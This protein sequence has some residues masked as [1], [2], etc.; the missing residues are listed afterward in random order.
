[1]KEIKLFP[2][3]GSFA[4]NKD[5]AKAIRISELTPA[6][7][8]NEKVALDFEGVTSATQSF[9]HALISEVIRREGVAVLDRLKFKNCD[10]TVKKMIAIVVSYMQ[11]TL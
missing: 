4:E 8:E 9:I 1:M 7:E 10:E 6:L 11:D 2:K 3:T 5:V